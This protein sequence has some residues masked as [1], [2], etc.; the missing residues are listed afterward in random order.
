MDGG[1]KRGW[2]VLLLVVVLVPVVV[3]VEWLLACCVCR[4]KQS[5]HVEG[6]WPFGAAAMKLSPFAHE[7]GAV[8]GKNCACE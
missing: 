5:R 3:R 4:V 1:R 8:W 2:L 7:K 6:T